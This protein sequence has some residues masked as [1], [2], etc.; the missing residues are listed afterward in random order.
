MQAFAALMM[1][2]HAL[3][4]EQ[5]AAI[6]EQGQLLI[7]A[8]CH[9]QTEPQ[10]V[11]SVLILSVAIRMLRASRKHVPVLACNTMDSTLTAM[12]RA[13]IDSQQREGQDEVTKSGM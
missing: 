5:M 10:S 7:G 11:R 6:S 4:H 9:R 2:N 8:Q 13:M 1:S 12:A 3:L